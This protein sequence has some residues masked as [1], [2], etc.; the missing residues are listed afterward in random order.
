M[1]RRRSAASCGSI[2][3]TAGLTSLRQGFGG[4]P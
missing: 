1:R 3:T 4:P 2:S